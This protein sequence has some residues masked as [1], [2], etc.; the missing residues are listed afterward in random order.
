[1]RI[2][3]GEFRGRALATPQAQKIRPTSD[4]VRENLFNIIAHSYSDRLHGT[5]VLDLFAGSGA[6]GIEAISRGS[7]FVLFVESSIEGR[8]L[9]RQNVEK[10]SLQGKSKIYRRDATDL[11]ERGA[12]PPFD[13]VFADPP[14]NCG[15][16]ELAAASL[17]A[18]GWLA[19]GA[20]LV[21]EE[22]EN[23]AP[24]SLPGYDCIER[25]NY[26]GTVVTMFT[27]I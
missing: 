27:V 5:R 23:S 26:S 12:L 2:V 7:R 22:A 11:G 10:F 14:Y 8:S 13:L 16:G 17:L 3:G 1:M 15:F 24:A 9:L 20:L 6:L 25:R 19:D 18:H 4:R 21:L